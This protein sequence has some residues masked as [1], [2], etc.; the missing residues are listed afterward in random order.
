MDFL[1][2]LKRLWYKKQLKNERFRFLFDEP[3]AGEYVSIDCETTGLDTKKDEIL[4]IG[5]VRIKNNTLLTS[6]SLHLWVRPEG[7]ISAESIKVHHLRHCDLQDAMPLSEALERLLY[8][9]GSRP[10]VGYYLEFDTAMI[11]RVVKPLLGISLP[12]P[13]IEV[14]ALYHDYKVEP[15]PQ[16]F[17]DLRFDTILK[18]LGLP[19]LGKHSALNDAVMAALIFMKLT[20]LKKGA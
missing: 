20:Q 4:S 13:Q 7:T 16:G 1:Y 19:L 15:I 11:G 3:P 10:L 12:N 17:I 18:D 9:I 5:A 2:P 14:S 6:E 8:F